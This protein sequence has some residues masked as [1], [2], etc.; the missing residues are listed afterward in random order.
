MPKRSRVHPKYKT[1]YRVGN[2]RQY[3]AVLVRRGDISIWL[4]PEAIRAWTPHP[5]RT[6]GRPRRYSEL[7]V[8]T[9]LTL[10]L[11]FGLPWRQTEGLLRS[12]LRLMRLPLPTPDHT[13]LSRRA[14][15]SA[16]RA[17]SRPSD[18][19]HLVVDATGLKVFG[20]GEWATWKHGARSGPGWKKL[21]LGVDRNGFI[22]AADVTDA[23]VPDGVVGPGLLAQLGSPL[24]SFTADGA[25]DGR[26]VYEAV[27]A[28][29]PAPCIVVPPSR[30]ATVSGEARLAQRD[31]AV[32]A[33][34]RDGRSRWKKDVGY[35]QQAR[36][37][38]AIGRYK[39]TFGRRIRARRE[40]AQRSEVSAACAVLNRMLE[41]GRPESYAVV[42]S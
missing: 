27:L 15:S 9:A 26:P 4:H 1:K 25:Y 3:E 39:Q 32:L 22:V 11:I 38:C 30:T 14:R 35:H 42:D 31:A 23:Y 2:W 7:A 40:D 16:V 33:I 21:H 6:Q 18:S 8:D 37:E 10:R 24:L 41:L 20:Q 17:A 36:A 29:G 19:I 34:Q 5:S 28:A 13:T 12:L